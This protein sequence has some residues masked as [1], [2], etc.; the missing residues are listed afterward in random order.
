LCHSLLNASLYL[1]LHC[2]CKALEASG[3]NVHDRDKDARQQDVESG[4]FT[5]RDKTERA[6]KLCFPCL[7]S[8]LCIVPFV[9]GALFQ[10]SCVQHCPDI[11]LGEAA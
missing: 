1:T 10:L 11:A 6:A 4:C 5:S 9:I 8:K 3:G 7:A 2:S